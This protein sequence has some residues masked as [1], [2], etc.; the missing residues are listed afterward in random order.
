VT[1]PSVSMVSQAQGVTVK[2]RPALSVDFEQLL[3]L[4]IL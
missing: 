2:F 3:N 1:G 4:F